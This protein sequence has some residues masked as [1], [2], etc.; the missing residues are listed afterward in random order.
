MRPG[1][2]G[3]NRTYYSEGMKSSASV[4]AAA[5][6]IPTA[7]ATACMGSPPDREDAG[8]DFVRTCDSAVGGTLPRDYERSSAVA[9][10][11]TLFFFGQARANGRVSLVPRSQFEPV[12]GTDDLFE[13]FKVL[14]VVRPG[15]VVALEVP[16]DEPH[17]SLLY[18]PAK[19]AGAPFRVEDGDRA[20]TFH[21]CANAGEP[22]QFNGGFVVAGARCANLDVI[23]GGRA[24]VPIVLSFGERRCA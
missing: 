4:L 20:V 14:A 1:P 11:L 8:R 5:L 19:L 10:P 15:A 2:P 23:S 24:P 16:D 12:A 3:R 21:A 22:T 9:G 17:V 13:P 6:V 18:D 7:L